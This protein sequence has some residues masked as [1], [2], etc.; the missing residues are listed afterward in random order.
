MLRVR[1][2]VRVCGDVGAACPPP[3]PLTQHLP[4]HCRLRRLLSVRPLQGEAT[5]ADLCF[6]LQVGMVGW[7][8]WFCIWAKK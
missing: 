3:T 2:C 5:P 7:V 8:G 4:C 6:S 1:E